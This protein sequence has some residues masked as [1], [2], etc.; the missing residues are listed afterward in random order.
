MRPTIRW[1]TLTIDC[2]DAEALAAFYAQVLGWEVVD[3][4][5]AGWVQLCDPAGG[6]GLNVQ[7]EEGYQAPVWPD[8][9]GHQAKMMHLEILVDDLDAAVDEV[10]AAGG[11][12]AP[13]QPPDR[14]ATRLRVMLDPAGHPFCLF[15]DGE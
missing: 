12:Q 6:V 8:Q 2:A 11:G 9:V 10:L 4:D 3:R 7:A 14:D 1:T 13:H 5:G 15:V